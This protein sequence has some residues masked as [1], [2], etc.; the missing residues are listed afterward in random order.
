M[1]PYILFFCTHSGTHDLSSWRKRWNLL[2]EFGGLNSNEYTYIYLVYIL[3]WEVQHQPRQGHPKK[4]RLTS[5]LFPPPPATGPTSTP[6]PHTHIYIY[7]YRHTT[8]HKH[9]QIWC[10]VRSEISHRSL[11]ASYRASIYYKVKNSAPQRLKHNTNTGADGHPYGL[12]D[13]LLTAAVVPGRGWLA[14]RGKQKPV[15]WPW[16]QCF[17]GPLLRELMWAQQVG[18]AE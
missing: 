5:T 11:S 12:H 8:F 7:I 2:H 16:T 6:P 10:T 4:K 15:L 18:G 13:L 17:F 3:W 14:T 9:K 1:A